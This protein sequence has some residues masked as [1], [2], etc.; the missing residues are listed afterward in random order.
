[1]WTLI[2]RRAAHPSHLTMGPAEKLHNLTIFS[3]LRPFADVN[4]NV[5][6]NSSDAVRRPPRGRKDQK[7]RTGTPSAPP[8]RGISWNQ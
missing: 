2:K 4:K 6:S 3:L 5:C 7:Y 8:A 1:V